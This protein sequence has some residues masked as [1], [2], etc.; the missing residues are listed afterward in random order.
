M[1]FV[2]CLA[3]G[4]CVTPLR[5]APPKILI[6]VCREPAGK[7]RNSVE[8][9]CYKKWQRFLIRLGLAHT[10]FIATGPH[11]PLEFSRRGRGSEPVGGRD[12]LRVPG[13]RRG[14][15]PRPTVRY[16]FRSLELQQC[17][18]G[19]ASRP[20]SIPTIF[21]PL[22]ISEYGGGGEGWAGVS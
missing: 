8:G 18:G 17:S 16:G 1:M 4:K 10:V 19:L 20:F 2:S 5:L 15:G 12:A 13:R 6:L 3:L 21:A 11:P 9:S 22:S 14:P 7:T